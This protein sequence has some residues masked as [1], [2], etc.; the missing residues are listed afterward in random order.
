MSLRPNLS[1]R[2]SPARLSLPLLTVLLANCADGGPA[3]SPEVGSAVRAAQRPSVHPDTP[4]VPGAHGPGDAP[5][6]ARTP[7]NV[8]VSASP[9]RGDGLTLSHAGVA[10]GVEAD[11]PPGRA[12]RLVARPNAPGSFGYAAWTLSTPDGCLAAE[13]QDGGEVVL[14][15]CDDP[16]VLRFEFFADSGYVFAATGAASDPWYAVA[17][18]PCE[19][20][21]DTCLLLTPSEHLTAS[22]LTVDAPAATIQPARGVPIY[23]LDEPTSCLRDTGTALTLAPCDPDDAGQAWTLPFFASSPD[24]QLA[25]SG[26]GHCLNASNP[27]GPTLDLTCRLDA[28]ATEGG[29]LSDGSLM[30][31]FDGIGRYLTWDAQHSLRFD[32]A[33]LPPAFGFGPA[34]AAKKNV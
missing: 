23:A 17:A 24:G 22:E 32:G 31:V 1:R 12:P 28:T 13:H 27:A 33:G 9:S 14:A 5:A 10:F 29:G 2:R 20:G 16:H 34:Q 25:R 26:L 7:A 3:A 8:R 30:L 19:V 18:Q 15:A 11:G 4:A 6:A 21:T